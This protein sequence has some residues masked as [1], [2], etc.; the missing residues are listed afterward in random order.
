[1]KQGDDNKTLPQVISLDQLEDEEKPASEPL[2]PERQDEIAVSGTMPDP[3]SD[4]DTL[5]NAQNVGLQVGENTE[6]PEEIDIA[7]DIDKAED[8]LRTH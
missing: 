8:S 4:D 1:M 7:R 6:H 2:S 5:K 3:E